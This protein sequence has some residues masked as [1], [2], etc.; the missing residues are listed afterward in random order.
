MSWQ[1]HQTDNVLL[2][3]DE[4][5]WHFPTSGPQEYSK[6]EMFSSISEEIKH[7]SFALT[8]EI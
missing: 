1:A 6:Y 8:Y 2:A 7:F 5:P 3:S 4:G